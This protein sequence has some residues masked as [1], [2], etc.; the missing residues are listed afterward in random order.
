[1]QSNPASSRERP[2]STS[3]T[4]ISET[5][6]YDLMSRLSSLQSQ[7]DLILNELGSLESR[8]GDRHSDVKASLPGN[9]ASGGQVENLDRKVDELGQT[10]RRIQGDLE[11]RD[12]R[13]S[14]TGLEKA[15]RDTQANLMNGLPAS[16]GQSMFQASVLCLRVSNHLLTWSVNSRHNIRP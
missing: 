6:F 1:M 10:I 11:G 4:S 3:D 5:Q 13:E 7:T 9:F 14:L 12:Y 2:F 8:M 15:L 16:V